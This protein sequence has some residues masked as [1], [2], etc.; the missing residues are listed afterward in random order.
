LAA[1][2]EFDHLLSIQEGDHG[3]TRA[4]T[5]SDAR[6]ALPPDMVGTRTKTR[7]GARHIRS[8]SRQN[9]QPQRDSKATQRILGPAGG[10]AKA[11]PT[12]PSCPTAWPIDH[13]H[14]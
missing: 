12:T 8:R 1:V 6:A 9:L 7:S 10:W 13:D 2:A 4:Q 11:A 5:H 14:L 3:E